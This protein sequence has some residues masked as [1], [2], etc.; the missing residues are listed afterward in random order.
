MDLSRGR[1]SWN[2]FLNMKKEQNIILPGL[3]VSPGLA[4]GKAFLYRDISEREYKVYT[5]RTH[6]VAD[7]YARIE[8]AVEEVIGDLAL[9][10][11]GIEREFDKE[12]AAI[13]QAQQEMLKGASLKKEFR[14]KLKRELVNAEHV[15]HCVFQE[16]EQRFL[17]M[18]DAVQQRRSF[19]MIDLSRRLLRAI[20]GVRRHSLES[21]PEGSV[22]IAKR[23]LPSDTVFLS[24]RSTVAVVVESGGPGSHCALLTRGMGIPTVGQIADL[25][26]KIPPGHTV[27]VDGLRGHVTVDPDEAS[28]SLFQ[29][30]IEHYKAGIKKARRHCHEPA[31][32]LDGVLI[33][34]TANIGCR[35]DAEL[36][37]EN[38]AD[39]IGLYRVETFFL[40][41]K[42][43]PSEEA[44][45]QELSMTLAS[46]KGKFMCVR[47]LDVG[48]DKYLPFLR[49]PVETNPFLGRRGVRLLLD[50][51]KLLDSQLRAF[52]RLS[53]EHDVH[54]LVPM[55]TLAEEMM[56]VRE[57]MKKIA[58]EMG[59]KDIPP[60]GAMIETPAA[61]LCV[62]G[63]A[64]YADFF[65]LGTNDLTQYVLAAGRENPLVNRYFREDHPAV[66]RLLQIVCSEAGD[67]LVAICGELAG[68]VEAVPVLLHAGIRLLSVAPPLVPTIKEAVRKTSAKKKMNN[69]D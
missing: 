67:K 1:V 15:I 68:R 34:V 33:P 37:A 54:I 49:L 24:R 5:I 28:L 47:L 57:R 13:F 58:S 4:M 46:F 30:E 61:A 8:Q 26:D 3:A 59:I 53:R 48:G 12:L 2:D 41:C 25:M 69:R 52:L 40:G 44:F 22:L 19:D 55:V 50:Y 11:A 60:I 6:Q 23:L 17:G 64:D 38:G 27:L 10:A 62:S 32:S 51:P 63:M 45:F 43:M 9:N 29:K 35:E 66:I 21:I 7:E 20:I 65:S 42:T 18:T 31:H 36:A 16:L 14:E 39:G 56:Q